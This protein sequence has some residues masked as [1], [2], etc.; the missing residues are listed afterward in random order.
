MRLRMPRIFK[1][2][3]PIPN[4]QVQFARNAYYI[5]ARTVLCF[6]PKL[7]HIYARYG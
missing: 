2:R 3:E 4:N 7:L 1:M 6:H 5:I